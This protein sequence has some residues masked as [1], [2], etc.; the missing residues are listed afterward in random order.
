MAPPLPRQ[1]VSTSHVPYWCLP[2]PGGSA[3]GLC[4]GFAPGQSKACARCD[5]R[6]RWVQTRAGVTSQGVFPERT[7]EFLSPCPAWA[8]AHLPSLRESS[9][10]VWLWCLTS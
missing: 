9:E 4:V 3:L 2:V 10:P 7:S 1:R 5:G 8:P 6:K